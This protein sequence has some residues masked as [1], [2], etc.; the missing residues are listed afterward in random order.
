MLLNQLLRPLFDLWP[1]KQVLKSTSVYMWLFYMFCALLIIQYSC[2]GV[3][4]CKFF[5]QSTDFLFL[6]GFCRMWSVSFCSQSVWMIS[7]LH[8]C[9][10]PPPPSH[11][12][13]GLPRPPAGKQPVRLSGGNAAFRLGPAAGWLQGWE[14]RRLAGSECLRA[15][16]K[17]NTIITRN[18]FFL[19]RQLTCS[20]AWDACAARRAGFLCF[21]LK[22][23][24]LDA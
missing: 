13:P 18:L 9:H 4:D 2:P 5:I 7:H 21:C 20:G 19:P 23:Q 3:T 17:K 14:P 22:L 10:P 12:L 8:S 15:G 24:G 16:K 6:K 11:L 1:L